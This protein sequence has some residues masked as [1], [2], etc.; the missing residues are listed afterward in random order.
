M[1]DKVDEMIVAK[2]YIREGE[3]TRGIVL[4]SELR[5]VKGYDFPVHKNLY[6]LLIKK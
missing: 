3:L 6:K 1:A 2:Y 4:R 5:N